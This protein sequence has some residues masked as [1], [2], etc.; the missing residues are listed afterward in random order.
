ML[1]KIQLHEKCPYDLFTERSKPSL[2]DFSFGQEVVFWQP[3]VKREKL[4]P[5]GQRDRYLGSAMSQIAHSVP[6]A[7]R[8]WCLAKDDVV[9][10][11]HVKPYGVRVLLLPSVDGAGVQGSVREAI[12]TPEGST[13]DA[14]DGAAAP[15]RETRDAAMNSTDAPKW[16]IAMDRELKAFRRLNVLEMCMVPPGTN[17]ISCKWLFITKYNSDSTLS[18]HK[19]RLVAR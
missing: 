17:L 6:G 7:H 10:V 3:R 18:K 5:P 4:D 15:T 19:A 12:G 16:K 14:G 1:P 9:T 13:S 2:P 8:I 11:L